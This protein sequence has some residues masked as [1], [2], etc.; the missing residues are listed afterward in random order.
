[1][2]AYPFGSIQGTCNRQSVI[3]RLCKRFQ[4]DDNVRRRY[5]TLH[6]LQRLIRAGLAV[7]RKETDGAQHQTILVSSL[8]LR[9]RQFQGSRE[10]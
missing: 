10:P 2:R 7:M 3:S 9:V 6:E 5:T 4:N 8:Q 1:M